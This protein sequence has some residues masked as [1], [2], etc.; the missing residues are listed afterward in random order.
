MLLA[1]VRQPLDRAH[2]DEVEQA[3]GVLAVVA[4]HEVER[5]AVDARRRDEL[6]EGDRG[7]VGAVGDRQQQALV[8]GVEDAPEGHREAALHLATPGPRHDRP[9]GASR[10][11]RSIRAGSWNEIV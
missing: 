4:A 7:A 8:A 10:S 2:E 1:G 11:P 6:A 5:V 9:Q 3:V